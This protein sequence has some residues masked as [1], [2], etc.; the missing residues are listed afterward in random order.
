MPRGPSHL[1][2]GDGKHFGHTASDR[3]RERR[4]N[5]QRMPREGSSGKL[6]WRS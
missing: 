1:A 4:Q 6:P 2:Q 3:T 5:L